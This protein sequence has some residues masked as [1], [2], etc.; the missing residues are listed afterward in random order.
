MLSIFGLSFWIYFT[1]NNELIGIKIHE[2]QN[3]EPNLPKKSENSPKHKL[4]HSSSQ[5]FRLQ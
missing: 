2:Y 4:A 3:Y 1:Y 5:S